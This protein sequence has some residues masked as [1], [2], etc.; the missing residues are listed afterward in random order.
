MKLLNRQ[1]QNQISTHLSFGHGSN[2]LLNNLSSKEQKVEV[3]KMQVLEAFFL[4]L[5][6]KVL[7]GL[8]IG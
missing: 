1:A 6:M 4:K 3:K 5:C 8:E 2:I 7:L